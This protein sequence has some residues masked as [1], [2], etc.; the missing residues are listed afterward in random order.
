MKD[1]ICGSKVRHD[2]EAEAWAR[3][4]RIVGRD[5]SRLRAYQCAQCK[6]WHLTKQVAR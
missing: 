3:A 5:V 2:S 1:I 6:G 4:S